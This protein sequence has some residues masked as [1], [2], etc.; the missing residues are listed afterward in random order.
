MNTISPKQLRMAA[1]CCLRRGQTLMELVVAL[2][3]SAM[4]LA[5]LGSVMLIARQVAFTPS[6]AERRIDAA[7]VFGDLSLELRYATAIIEQTSKTLEFVVADRNT[8][9]T[10]ER[11]RYTW[12]GTVG[13]PLYK[14]VNGDTPAAVINSVHDFQAIYVLKSETTSL[15]TTTESAEVTLLAG[16]TPSGTQYN[17]IT[18]TNHTAQL[19]DPSLFTSLAPANA[20]YWN[21]TRIAFQ[22]SQGGGS[23][24]TLLVQLRPTGDPNNGPTNDVAGQVSVS[25]ST[26]T[27]TMG[28]NTATFANQVRGLSLNRSYAVTWST[29][30]SGPAARILTNDGATSGVSETTNTGA[31]WQYISPRQTYFTLYGTYTTPGPTYSITR[32]RVSHVAIVL[33]S[34]SQSHARIDA[35]IPLANVPELLSKYWRT[36]FDRDP[37][38]TN[39]NGDAV[40]DWA[41]NSGSFNAGSLSGGIWNATGVL[42]TRPLHDFT[43][44]T[45]IETRCRNTSVGG[46]GAVLVIN[47]DRSG[48]VHTTLMIYLQRQADGTQT[49]TLLTRPTS[50]T[51]KTLF[52]RS[53]LSNDY[54]RLRL[55]IDAQNNVVN[56]W[57]NDEDQGALT[58]STYAPLTNDRFLTLY[59]DTS[60]ADFDFIEVRSAAN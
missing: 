21:A 13:D 56:L 54:V 33:Q 49:L 25:E 9:G 38:T 19:L 47:A 15:K 12:S 52:T 3:A 14:S 55:L 36:D 29:A 48:G 11:I 44:T 32:N 22:A 1:N 28:W 39:A 59:A 41:M 5:G 7:D 50:N 18:S 10:A 4:L 27:G 37:T 57:I 42:E 43:T 58:F 30:N 51:T 34:G 45:V 16:G 2:V 26:L 35:R 40:A 46:N 24:D 60:T 6:A 17:D 23:T 53:R 20:L 8:D 31:S